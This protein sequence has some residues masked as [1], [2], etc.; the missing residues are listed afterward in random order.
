M[1][2]AADVRLLIEVSNSS[3]RYDLGEKA[4]LYA[5]AGIVEYWVV[6]VQHHCVN[7]MTEPID[8]NYTTRRRVTPP[9]T[10]TP[11]CGADRPLDLAALFADE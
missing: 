2:E 4:D 1:P 5:A 8:G 7:C 10:L 9:E 11:I 6:D 3:L